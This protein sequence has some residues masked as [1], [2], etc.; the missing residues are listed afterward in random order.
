MNFISEILFVL[1][2]CR[3][4]VYEKPA[5]IEYFMKRQIDESLCPMC[6]GRK[7]LGTT[8]YGLN[9]GTGIVVVRNVSAQICVQCGEEWI[10]NKTAQRLERI[11]KE[12]R[13]RHHQVEV[14]A[15]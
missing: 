15:L 12:A 3:R 2:Q 8:T 7:V 1:T 11:V 6:G 9:L 10:D 4:R 14:V 13:A 5:N